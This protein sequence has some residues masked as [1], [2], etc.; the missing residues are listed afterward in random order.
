MRRIGII[1]ALAA[2]LAL[3]SAAVVTANHPPGPPDKVTICHKP[4]TPDAE[5]LTV[6]HNAWEKG[7]SRH[8]DTLGSCGQGRIVFSSD[9]DGDY[10]IY[11]MDADGS[12]Q[13]PLTQNND[14]DYWPVWS[15]DASKIAFYSDRDG[16]N[17]IYVMDANGDNQTPL[18]HTNAGEYYPAW[19]PGSRI[20]FNSRMDGN[21]EI[22]V[23]DANGDNVERLTYNAP[24]IDARANWFPDEAMLVYD[25]P[26]PN[27]GGHSPREIYTMNADGTGSVML[28]DNFDEDSDAEVSPD[29]T[30]IAYMRCFAAPYCE[31]YVMNADGSNQTNRTN[32][33]SAGQGPI[34]NHWPG[35]SP[36]STKIVFGSNRGGNYDI[37]VMNDDGTGQTPLT[38]D[39]ASDVTPAW[40]PV[41]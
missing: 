20:A 17:E 13:T 4:G 7:H 6:P 10:E 35:W 5:T 15:P 41:P 27:S 38:N 21:Q 32:S 29:G 40:E 39:G 16:N 14:F 2:I 23:M 11:I 25:S 18:N 30:R 3:G 33:L 12:N 34:E 37:Y 22:Y 24:A 8:G 19:F 31:I 28:T 36:D 9:R 1:A 26:G